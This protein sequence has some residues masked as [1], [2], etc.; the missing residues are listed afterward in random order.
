MSMVKIRSADIDDLQAITDIYNHA[1]VNTTSTFDTEPLT[2]DEQNKWFLEHGPKN[3][4]VVAELDESVVGWASLSEWSRRCAY[5]DTA[6]ISIYVKKD[7]Q[8]TGIGK[9]LM[10][11]ILKK[12]EEAGLHTVVARIVEGSDLSVHLHEAAGFEHIGIMKEAGKKFGK[13]LDVILMQYIYDEH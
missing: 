2:M 10:E 4:I 11:A 12:G 1:V 8:G 9:Q 7:H 5:T 3:P 6:E 13:L